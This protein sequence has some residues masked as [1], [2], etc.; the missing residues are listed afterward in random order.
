MILFHVCDLTTYVPLQTSDD[1]TSENVVVF[2][3]LIE[4]DAYVRCHDKDD[5]QDLEMGYV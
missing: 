3:M 1:E 2:R 4:C 5:E